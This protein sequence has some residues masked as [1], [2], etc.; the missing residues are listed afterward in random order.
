LTSL[1][2]QGIHSVTKTVMTKPMVCLIVIVFALTTQISGAVAGDA[3]WDRTVLPRP[4]QLFE[5][6]AKRTLE[7]SGAAFT[8]PVKLLRMRRT[9]FS[10]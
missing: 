7:G 10:C 4:A 2:T 6:V 9:F 3:E 8:N 5:G 1:V